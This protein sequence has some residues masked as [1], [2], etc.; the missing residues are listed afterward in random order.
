MLG[1]SHS[2]GRPRRMARLPSSTTSVNG[3]EFSKLE[4]AGGPPLQASSHSTSSFLTRGRLTGGSPRSFTS[5]SGVVI[6]LVFPRLKKNFPF[7]PIMTRS[8]R[9]ATCSFD[10]ST[11]ERTSSLGIRPPSYQEKV[12][13]SL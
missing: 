11:P 1:P 12:K 4:S 7:S 6:H 10:R 2:I 13:S 9:L 8:N 3:P 5:D